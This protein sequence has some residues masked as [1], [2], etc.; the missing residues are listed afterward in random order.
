MSRAHEHWKSLT[1]VCVAL[2]A[3]DA[4]AASPL[5]VGNMQPLAFGR[6]AA[7]PGGSVTINPAGARTAGG[8][9]ALVGAGGSAARFTVSGDADAGYSITLPANGTVQLVNGAGQG[10][11]VNGF[12]SNPN[13]IGRLSPVGGTQAIAIGA[14]LEVGANQPPGTYSASFSVSVDYN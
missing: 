1:L 13:T 2:G 9:V 4:G 10:M 12:S 14:T 6:F 3:I 7:G 5:V 11:A 8:G